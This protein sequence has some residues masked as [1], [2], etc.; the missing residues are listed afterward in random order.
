MKGEEGG[1]HILVFRARG[2]EGESVWG[3]YNSR[4]E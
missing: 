2:L 1:R 4:G 3:F